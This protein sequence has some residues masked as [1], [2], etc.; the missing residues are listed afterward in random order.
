MPVRPARR[1]DVAALSATL[2]R[3]FQDDPVAVWVYRS[4]RRRPHWMRRFFV[5]QLL[6]LLPQETVWVA[7]DLAGAAIWAL[8]DRWREDRGETLTLLRATLPG[9]LPRLPRVARGLAE[10]EAHHPVLPH[11]YLVSLGVAPE[12]QRRGLGSALLAPGLALCDQD[13][14]P[15]YLE[16][17]TEANVAFY[18]RHGFR[19]TGELTLTRGPR[20]W[21][22]W[23]DPA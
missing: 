22:M 6:R 21:L 1:Q 5:W 16:T 10:I 7:D 13:G 18:A 4:A 17:A 19:V 8:P 20:V 3:A 2:A 9:I 14:L 23:R 11:L 12:Q 15:A